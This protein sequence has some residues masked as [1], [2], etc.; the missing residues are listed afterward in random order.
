MEFRFDGV[1]AH[2]QCLL[3]G[4]LGSGVRSAEFTDLLGC[5]IGLACCVVDVA[6]F[7]QVV[8]K[9]AE[10]LVSRELDGNPVLEFLVDFVEEK[11]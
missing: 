9:E 3:E 1:G 6:A 5:E 4:F 7:D 8:E 11:F 10:L 2:V